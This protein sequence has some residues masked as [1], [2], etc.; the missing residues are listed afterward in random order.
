MDTIKNLL[1][2]IAP[3]LAATLGGPIGG[4]GVLMA[5]AAVAKFAGKDPDD[6]DEDL[7]GSL[8]ALLT[9]PA[10]A[11]EIKRL[12]QEFKVQMKELDLKESQAI[13]A[14]KDSARRM[15]EA[16]GANK[17][18]AIFLI[19]VALVVMEFLV[20]VF[21][22]IPE[23]AEAIVHGFTGATLTALV[24]CYQFWNGTT[25]GSKMKTFLNGRGK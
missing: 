24:N 14:D 22:N 1:R 19:T 15:T 23:S 13:L 16:T 5:R 17:Q 21:V 25:Y 12:D 9:D 8:K 4:V 10:K 2:G 18:F 11:A 6:S 3:T 20:I 7:A